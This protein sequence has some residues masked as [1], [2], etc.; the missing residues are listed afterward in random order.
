M[1]LSRTLTVAGLALAA[2]AMIGTGVASADPSA[3]LLGNSALF[4]TTCNYDQLHRALATADP[5]TTAALDAQ[6]AAP[7]EAA[8]RAGARRRRPHVA[9]QPAPVG[10]DR[11]RVRLPG[12]DGGAEVRVSF[13]LD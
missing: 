5:Q 12:H 8:Q 7:P 2:S 10:H 9:Q 1:K 6:P 4:N 11:A 3:G 13:L